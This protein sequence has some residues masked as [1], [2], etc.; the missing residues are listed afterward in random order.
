M[1]E[2]GIGWDKIQKMINQSKKNGDPIANMI[3]KINFS[4]NEVTILL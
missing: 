1:V 2:G 3:F 4:T